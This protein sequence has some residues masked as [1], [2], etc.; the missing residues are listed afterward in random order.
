MIHNNSLHR[1]PPRL[2]RRHRLPM[3]T[4]LHIPPFGALRRAVHDS[5]APWCRFSVTSAVQ[6]KSWWPDGA[7]PEAEVVHNGIDLSL[8]PYRPEG[9]GSA[10]WAGR[11]TPNKGTHLAVRAA[12]LAGV[13]L[14]LFGTVEHRDYFEQEVRPLLGGD[15][16]YGGHLEGPALADELGRAS[17]LLFTPLWDEP[18]GLAAIEAMACGLP[19]AST[20]M[21]AVREVIGNAGAYAPP[22]DA[23]ALAQ[24]L[25][26]ALE[27]PRSEAR[28]RVERMFSLSHMVR[29]Y[30]TLYH[31]AR[32]GLR[33]HLPCPD[34]AAIELD[35]APAMPA[36]TGT[37]LRELEGARS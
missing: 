22:D 33:Q 37:P 32:A 30:E 9:D 24:A 12:Q 13:P 10:V 34:P 21:G 27:I 26:V 8:W 7:P 36:Q 28:A 35:I 6:T 1:Y 25:R 3:L 19:V 4:S 17:A 2:A 5:A 16:R 15:R 18:F 20:E 31:A 14:T 11:I 23:P 29:A